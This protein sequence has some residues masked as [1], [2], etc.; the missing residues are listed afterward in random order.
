[1]RL[2][3]SELLERLYAAFANEPLFR[4]HRV[5]PCA[6][7]ARELPV[8]DTKHVGYISITVK[9]GVVTLDGDVESLRHKRLAGHLAWWIAGVTDV[10]NGLGVEP[11]QSDS[12]EEM[13]VSVLTALKKDPEVHVLEI[14]VE[15]HDAVV[16]LRGTVHS[17]AEARQAERDAWCTF[18][19]DRVENE[20][21]IRADAHPA[22]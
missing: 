22:M 14:D 3:D 17:I 15:T 4:L 16:H 13:S 21:R 2:A 6:L 8:L 18:G 9:D 12:D 11:P 1:M 10:V 5:I 19:V 7:S 20:L